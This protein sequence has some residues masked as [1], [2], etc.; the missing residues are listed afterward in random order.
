MSEL[1]RTVVLSG[2]VGDKPFFFINAITYIK[3]LVNTNIYCI[4]HEL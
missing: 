3:L 2:Q 4:I 1:L